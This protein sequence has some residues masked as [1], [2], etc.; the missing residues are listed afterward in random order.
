[1]IALLSEFSVLANTSP[2]DTADTPIQI[3]FTGDLTVPSLSAALDRL[4]YSIA[5]ASASVF[6]SQIASI[7]AG[8]CR[9][10]RAVIK[11]IGKL[12]SSF[13]YLSTVLEYSEV[14]A[15]LTEAKKVNETPICAYCAGAKKEIVTKI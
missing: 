10:V 11:P 6:C 9:L 12:T 4:L 13:Q 15:E 8:I 14:V 3:A 2:K 7:S 5:R 1:M